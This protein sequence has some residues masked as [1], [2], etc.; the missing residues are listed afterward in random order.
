MLTAEEQW[1]ILQQEDRRTGRWKRKKKTLVELL[2]DMGGFGHDPD[3]EQAIRK[4]LERTDTTPPLQYS[5][6]SISECAVS[7]GESSFWES[8][9]RLFNSWLFQADRPNTWIRKKDL[10]KLFRF[11]LHRPIMDER[12]FHWT[13]QVMN[14]QLDMSIGDVRKPYTRPTG[15][16]RELMIGLDVD[17]E[18]DI[19]VSTI[20]RDLLPRETADNMDKAKEEASRRAQQDD[21]DVQQLTRRQLWAVYEHV[22]N[23]SVELE[24]ATWHYRD[25][26]NSD[27]SNESLITCLQHYGIPTDHIPC[28]ERKARRSSAHSPFSKDVASL[29]KEVTSIKTREET[30]VLKELSN[31]IGLYRGGAFQESEVIPMIQ[32][33]LEGL[34]LGSDA[35]SDI[36]TDLEKDEETCALLM[37][38]DACFYNSSS[39]SEEEREGSP[40]AQE[41]I[42]R[43]VLVPESHP[44]EGEDLDATEVSSTHR[45]KSRG[46]PATENMECRDVFDENV[47]EASEASEAMSID[48]PTA[49][50]P[51]NLPDKHLTHGRVNEAESSVQ[52]PATPR[53]KNASLPPV[54]EEDKSQID[55]E[56]DDE[57]PRGRARVRRRSSSPENGMTTG[58]WGL[59]MPTKEA[60]EL[61]HKLKLPQY[62]I[63]EQVRS[64]SRRRTSRRRASRASRAVSFPKS[65]RK[66][67]LALHRDTPSK[68]PKQGSN[69]DIFAREGEDQRA[70]V[71]SHFDSEAI[72]SEDACMRCSRSP[73]ECAYVSSLPPSSELDDALLS[74][75]PSGNPT[76]DAKL[77]DR[78]RPKPQKES[79][80]LLAWLARLLENDD[81]LAKLKHLERQCLGTRTTSDAKKILKHMQQSI[82]DGTMIDISGDDDR[83]AL[84]ILN[85]LIRP[86]KTLV[87]K[88]HE[89]DH[90]V[91]GEKVPTT[92]ADGCHD[93][94]EEDSD[95]ESS[96]LNSS[97][98]HKDVRAPPSDPVANAAASQETP[99]QVTKG[100]VFPGISSPLAKCVSRSLPTPAPESSAPRTERSSDTEYAVPPSGF[101]AGTIADL[102]KAD[103]P[104]STETCS[105]STGGSKFSSAGGYA[106]G[107]EIPPDSS[108]RSPPP[109]IADRGNHVS[110][111][112]V[113]VERDT[114]YDHFG[115]PL[116]KQP[117]SNFRV[118]GNSDVETRSSSPGPGVREAHGNVSPPSPRVAVEDVPT[119]IPPLSSKPLVKELPTSTPPETPRIG[120]AKLPGKMNAT[121]QSCLKDSAFDSLPLW[122][123][124]PGLPKRAGKEWMSMTPKK[125]LEHAKTEAFSQRKSLAFYLEE[126]RVIRARIKKKN[127]YANSKFSDHRFFQSSSG[128]AGSSGNATTLA[129]NK[130][131]DKYRGMF[132]IWLL[133]LTWPC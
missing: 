16:S 132:R 98:S 129:L 56:T 12:T 126:R 15:R 5:K 24:M 89:S 111:Q 116:T 31:Y 45:S 110:D 37:W 42:L 96:L 77:T 13:L 100:E 72:L 107:A 112:S 113:D 4:D 120:H 121:A 81:M 95:L 103:H 117:H 48:K 51:A 57:Q 59:L 86:S 20:F 92:S 73:C 33:C 2:Q 47:P 106:T 123:S 26:F 65:K 68:S 61:A 62:T 49:S 55:T 6:D 131:F 75:P 9:K 32:D 23:G 93:R 87:D 60:R 28:D 79:V 108:A 25:A 63:D 66:A 35:I 80:T 29:R 78:S 46:M 34:S 94:A 52:P 11:A 83:E 50:P 84:R 10:P 88:S 69:S 125:A 101:N 1:R 128:S 122:P 71:L 70:F 7:F 90:E 30:E 133:L 64:I 76:F 74:Q 85:I 17:H 127:D 39:S 53:L 67:S 8:R 115:A 91:T 44:N 118:T 40:E 36:L 82:H 119:S 99:S 114:D 38:E 130:L 21:E 41:N 3:S 27:M 105:T 19:H 102:T 18:K 43:P 97:P 58:I 14:V 124:Q 22:Q 104:P 109:S 54:I